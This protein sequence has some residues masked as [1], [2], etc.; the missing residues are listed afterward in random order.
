MELSITNFPSSPIR[1]IG[2]SVT[3]NCSCDIGQ[4]LPTRYLDIGVIVSISLRDPSGRLLANTTPPVTGSLYTSSAMI[5][6]FGRDQ[7]GIYTCTASVRASSS[8]IIS[9]DTSKRK[10]VTIGKIID[11]LAIIIMAY[12][13]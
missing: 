8:F 5:S 12:C 4:S 10:Q 2:T 6:S 3:L 11:E 13:G 9:T 7:S 1:P